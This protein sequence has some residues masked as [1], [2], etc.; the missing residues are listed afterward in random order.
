M[1]FFF[2]PELIILS[3]MV[4][5][6]GRG[7]WGSHQII[8]VRISPVISIAFGTTNRHNINDLGG[9]RPA[10]PRGKKKHMNINKLAGLSWDWAGGRILFICCLGVIR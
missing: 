5:F 10:Q 7:T 2:G 3:P 4:G 8:Y 6:L 9:R 1:A